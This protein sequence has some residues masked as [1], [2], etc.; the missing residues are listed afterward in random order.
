MTGVYIFT[1]HFGSGKTETAVNFAL[2]LKQ[3]NAHRKIA[4]IDMDIVNPFFRSADS[5]A[6]LEDM[7]IRVEVPLYANS[8]VDVPALTPAMSSLIEN[9]EYDVIIDVGGDD[10]GAKAV[11]RY[12]DI[13][14][15]R[16]Y[17]QF[18]VVNVRRP[19]TYNLEAAL[20]IFDEIELT[21][22]IKATAIIN[23]ANMMEG[24]SI[25]DCL[26]G[27]LLANEI[28]QVKKIPVAYHAV[29]DSVADSLIEQYPDIFTEEN[30]IRINR[31]V[32]RL[33]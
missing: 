28:G 3:A 15:E 25:S 4:L 13:I 7:G 27:N 12:S 8:N 24:T 30:V 23:S 1:G 26:A 18:F 11:G 14:K 17:H 21:S 20:K 32:K 33:F 10:I 22:N 6:A 31:M 2:K 29:T 5:K 9:T 16:N 19:F